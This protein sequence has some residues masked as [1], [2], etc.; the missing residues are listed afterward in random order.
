MSPP[1]SGWARLRQTT[2]GPIPAPQ[3]RVQNLQTA[4][5]S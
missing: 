1:G 3:L 2:T 4:C 5:T